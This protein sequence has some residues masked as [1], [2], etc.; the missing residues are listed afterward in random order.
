VAWYGD[1]LITSGNQSF[2]LSVLSSKL[3]FIDGTL[4]MVGEEVRSI[5][6]DLRVSTN[7]SAKKAATVSQILRESRER[8]ACSRNKIK[9]P[10]VSLG[11]IILS[12]C[13][14]CFPKSC[15]FYTKIQIVLFIKARNVLCATPP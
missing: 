5:T 15:Y 2:E 4:M 12:S 14:I 10:I 13:G 3:M 1:Q 9:V 7:R 8:N 6:S 11:G